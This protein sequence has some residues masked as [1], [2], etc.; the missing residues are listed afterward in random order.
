MN[1][2]HLHGLEN[3][4]ACPS[5]NGSTSIHARIHCVATQDGVEPENEIDRMMIDTF[6]ETLSEVALAVAARDSEAKQTDE[7]D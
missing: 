1:E 5:L 2:D 7:R 4:D 3:S 6:L